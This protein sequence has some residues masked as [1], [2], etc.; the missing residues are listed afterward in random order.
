M[1]TV[2]TTPLRASVAANKITRRASAS[3]DSPKLGA[4]SGGDVLDIVGLQRTPSG[5]M[6]AQ[7]SDGWVTAMTREGKRLLHAD[8]DLQ[9]LLEA[10]QP[11]PEAEPELSDASPAT[12]TN[13]LQAGPAVPGR[14]AITD[15][16]RDT[17][18]LDHDHKLFPHGRGY[19]GPVQKPKTTWKSADKPRGQ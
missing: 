14:A 5:T 8:V 16:L 4:A 13:K 19:T 9:T 15:Q 17:P 3:T 18:F 2:I 6:R 12:G 7:T 1:T 11:E 10:R